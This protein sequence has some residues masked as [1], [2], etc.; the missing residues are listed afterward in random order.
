MVGQFHGTSLTMDSTRAHAQTPRLELPF[1]FFVDTIIAVI[2]LRMIRASANG[3][4]K[5]ARKNL[6]LLIARTHRT[7]IA[8][9]WQSAGK[10]GYDVV[11]CSRVVLGAVGVGDLQNVA[12]IL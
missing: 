8:V 12:S 1:I 9:V 4:Q 3:M 2:P 7:A 10:S 5:R 11:C 6:Q